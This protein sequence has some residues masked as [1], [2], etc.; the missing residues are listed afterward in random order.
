MANAGNNSNR[1]LPRASIRR[2]VVFFMLRVGY[3]L[4]KF[5]LDFAA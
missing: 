1:V 4:K 2:G 5:G 3:E